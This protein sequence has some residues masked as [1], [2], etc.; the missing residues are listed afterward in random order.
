MYGKDF[1]FIARTV[2]ST[3][4]S[5]VGLIPNTAAYR[6]SM[7]DQTSK[8]RLFKLYSSLP[9]HWVGSHSPVY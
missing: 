9:C 7:E 5:K 8:S 4:V 3:A 6:I 1:I 2:T